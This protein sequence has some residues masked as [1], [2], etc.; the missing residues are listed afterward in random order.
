[1]GER[2]WR[3]SQPCRIEHIRR[4]NA[5]RKRHVGLFESVSARGGGRSA[6]S[7]AASRAHARDSMHTDHEP[8]CDDTAH[9]LNS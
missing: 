7:L 5:P 6:G 8:K 4:L 3:R 9:L 2:A 1:M